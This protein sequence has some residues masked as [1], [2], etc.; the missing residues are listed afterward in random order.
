MNIRYVTFL[1]SSFL[2]VS[3][4]YPQTKILSFS[5][6]PN[7]VEQ[8]QP[9]FLDLN[10]EAQYHNSFDVND[11]H[12]NIIIQTP[13]D[14]NLVQP[15]FFQNVKE[16]IS[17]W[18]VGFTPVE[19]G[20]YTYYFH[21]QTQTDT[22]VSKSF[23]LKVIASKR[24]GFVRL[25]PSSDYTFQ[26]DSGTFFRAI[27]ENVA[28]T[29]DYE[30][31]FKKLNAN[32]CNFVRIWMCPW[33][34]YLEWK[35]PGLGQYHLKNAAQLDS[36]LTFAEKYGIYIMF[37]MDYH[38]VAQKDEGYFKEN[39]WSENPYNQK[40]GGPCITQA[41]LFTNKLA[42]KY[43]Q[44]RYHYIIARY[45]YSPNI[46]AWELWNE[47]DLTAGEPEHVIA[48]HEE[49]ASYI[50]QID[51]YNH[52]ITT[53]F[54]GVG[55]PDMWE[56]KQLDFS[57]THHYNN[58]NFA[59]SLPQAI[60][61]H[62]GKYHKPH[63]IGEFGVDFRG[64]AETKENDPDN[65]GFHNGL[66]AGFCSPTPI[67]PLSWWWDNLIDPYNLY[68]HFDAVTKFSQNI[69]ER[70]DI[71]EPLDFE[72][73][74][75]YEDST[76]NNSDMSVDFL[77]FPTKSWGK[78]ITGSFHVSPNGM[79][80]NKEHIP[81]FLFGERK[82][83]FRNPPT[84]NINYKN[85]GRFIIHVNHVSMNGL[86]KIYVDDTLVLEKP[87]PL[88]PGEG[89]WEWSELRDEWD[90]YQG[91][92]NKEYGI[93]IPAGAHQIRIENDGD[94]WIEIIKYNFEKCGINSYNAIKVLGFQQH[95]TIFLWLR[96]ENYSWKQVR[97]N[98]MPAPNPQIMLQIPIRG[99]GA[100]TIEWWDTYKGIII[101]KEI[102]EVEPNHQL[103]F[104]VP[105]ITN[106]IACK[107]TENRQP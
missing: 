100:Y 96:N 79:I 95:H 101:R 93:D 14:E 83:E 106:D 1:L 49:M 64:P 45:S 66:W 12:V 22:V 92:Y 13:S 37:C 21:V 59:E 46:L 98:G 11:I 81:S 54:S 53:S 68:F 67:I 103:K 62:Q 48:W 99:R 16:G 78:N 39:K 76:N 75:T 4:L 94:D 38:G 60:H 9:L 51:P 24:D 33:N 52:L 74:I 73:D 89:E 34:L 42:K 77:V 19:K 63:V 55:Y 61:H 85:G 71:I 107:I 80:E 27:G 105:A 35:E 102:I 72:P 18:G 69:C 36:V 25:H 31:Y 58:P 6:L 20:D 32:G 44:N 50:K 23:S 70:S 84:F 65:V 82:S 47:V 91:L 56:I 29:D 97:Y 7:Q 30:Y 26:F 2:M 41:E 28:W 86:L 88:G 17:S 10:I 57:Q 15:G 90:I 43:Q 40:N 3:N 8:F 87:L 5:T 104:K